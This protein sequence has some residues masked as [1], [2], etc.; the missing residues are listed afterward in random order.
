[1]LTDGFYQR[2]RVEAI[3]YAH[4][5]GGKRGRT[6]T[7]EPSVTS[8]L[9]LNEPQARSLAVGV[10]HL[11]DVVAQLHSLLD[12]PPSG[13]GMRVREA[14]IDPRQARELRGELAQIRAD[15]DALAAL[16]G[17]APERRSARAAFAALAS[18]A[19]TIAEDLHPAKLRRYG[20]VDAEAAAALAP[21]IE[22]LA[23]RFLAVA[24]QTNRIDM[25]ADHSGH[26]ERGADR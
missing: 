24:E 3:Y 25:E 15:L 17:L 9:L 10:R 1:M 20:A 11:S 13:D 16:L 14:D 12:P 2:K 5:A 23:A 26:Q 21:L 7:F 8:P 18:S 4:Q 6:V 22:R 19:W